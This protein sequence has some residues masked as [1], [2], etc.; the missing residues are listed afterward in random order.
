MWSPHH[1]IRYDQIS[2]AFSSRK[3]SLPHISQLSYHR[4]NCHK[5]ILQ[6][7]LY[8][9][10]ILPGAPTMSISL[11]CSSLSEPSGSQCTLINC[12]IF[13][14]SVHYIVKKFPSDWFNMLLPY[15]QFGTSWA[16]ETAVKYIMWLNH[17]TRLSLLLHLSKTLKHLTLK[18]QLN[19]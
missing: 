18:I 11:F 14:S 8:Q 6:L 12:I 16:H 5:S 7:M 2:P 9:W 19:K 15:G 10:F 3:Q 17:A 13:T 4:N 1:F